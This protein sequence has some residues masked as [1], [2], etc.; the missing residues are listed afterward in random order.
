MAVRKSAAERL[1]EKGRADLDATI[2]RII[3]E[4]LRTQA[5]LEALAIGALTS[6]QLG[7]LRFRRRQQLAVRKTIR[8]LE[9][10]LDRPLS[11]AVR[12][13]FRL[14]TR[15]ADK[16]LPEIK[17]APG[18]SRIDKE[19]VELLEDNITNRLGDA[20][21]TIGRRMDDIFRR[22]GLKIAAIQLSDELPRT[23]ATQRLVNQLTEQGVTSFQD[24]RGVRWNLDRYAE[25]VV[26]TTVSEAIFQGTQTQMLS[27]GFDLV[28]V[29]KSTRPCPDCRAL[30]EKTFSLTGRAKGYPRL[31]V[32][33]PVHPNCDH[34]VFPAPEAI[35]ER[36]EAVG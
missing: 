5:R 1:A 20:Q 33:F 14:G 4:H 30:E 10:A 3:E 24:S 35:E 29:S 28:T 12:D 11:K 6:G 26:R 25:M 9:A 22:E 13:A 36:R 21:T 18:I 2:R 23:K 17:L 8:D 31:E 27:R 15:I 34:F 7:V 19:A 16:G 32:T